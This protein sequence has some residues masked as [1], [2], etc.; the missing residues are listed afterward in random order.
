M[1]L[2]VRV[3]EFISLQSF[4]FV[5]TSFVEL[6]NSKTICMSINNTLADIV[7][8]HE[9]YYLHV[10]MTTFVESQDSICLPS[11]ISISALVSEICLLNGKKNLEIYSFQ[12][13]NSPS[14]ITYC[15]VLQFKPELPYGH[16][17]TLTKLELRKPQTESIISDFLIYTTNGKPWPSLYH[18]VQ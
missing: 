5:S 6:L 4:M 14:H 11:F 12:F 7:V 18:T 3:E 13:N 17:F 8:F 2:F 1:I 9:V 10:N 15:V 16:M